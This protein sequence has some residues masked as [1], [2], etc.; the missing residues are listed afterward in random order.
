M[1]IH[2]SQ[3]DGVQSIWTNQHLEGE[4]RKAL[5]W[6][7]IFCLSEETSFIKFQVRNSSSLAMRLLAIYTI[8]SHIMLCTYDILNNCFFEQESSINISFKGGLMKSLCLLY[9]SDIQ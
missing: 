9:R 5:T 8:I 6:T 3:D 7:L 4:G 2:K 1:A